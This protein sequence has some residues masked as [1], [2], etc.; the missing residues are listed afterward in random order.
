MKLTRL[1]IFLLILALMVPLFAMPASGA[2]D[3]AFIAVNDTIPLTLSGAELPFYNG[4]TLYLPYTAFNA[5][6]LGFYPSYNATINTLTLFSRNQRLVYD[7]TTGTV[8]DES[9]TI[10]TVSAIVQGGMVF[11]PAEFSAAHFGVQTSVL[12]SSGGY[13]VVRFTTGSQVY[14]DSLF[15]EKAENLIAY[16]VEQYLTP[17]VPDTSGGNDT[18]V[19]P[20]SQ[21]DTTPAGSDEEEEEEPVEAFLAV[22]GTTALDEALQAL[23]DAGASAVFFLTAGEITENS[24]LVRRIVTSGH[25]VGLT[26][27]D[28]EPVE[29]GLQLANEALDRVLNQKALMVLLP[30][31]AG[32]AVAD[33]YCVFVQPE[34]RLTASAA[35]EAYGEQRLLICTTEQLPA[36]LSILTAAGARLSRLTETTD[37]PDL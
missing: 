29:E 9:K 28:G 13:T 37:F 33:Q 20:P 3:L 2:S 31:G 30:E 22:T 25:T 34:V 24:A 35:V 8:S 10:F 15:I 32:D 18:P 14:N 7:L 36:A 21:P 11:L 4:N 12:T 26:V 19:S 16:R 17:E 6:S 27:A 5:S 23:E 1:L